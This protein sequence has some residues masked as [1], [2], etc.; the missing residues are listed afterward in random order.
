M[1]IDDNLLEILEDEGVDT[2]PSNGRFTFDVECEVVQ[3]NQLTQNGNRMRINVDRPYDD[4]NL[5][6][7][8]I[9]VI[10]GVVLAV[11]L[12]VFAKATSRWC[13]ADDYDNPSNAK[14]HPRS[15]AGG[16]RPA[17]Q[18]AQVYRDNIDET[19]KSA[20]TR[21]SSTSSSNN[22]VPI[23]S[24]MPTQKNGEW[25]PDSRKSAH[26]YSTPPTKNSNLNTPGSSK[27]K[28]GTIPKTVPIASP[29]SS[30]SS[31]SSSST[32]PPPRPPKD[33]LQY[34]NL[35][36]RAFMQDPKNRVLPGGSLPAS[37]TYATVTTREV[38]QTSSRTF[39]NSP[40]RQ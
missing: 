30:S 14:S 6:G 39:G 7:S 12:L 33:G 31:S 25:L 24:T 3:G 29:S 37:Q 16:A 28:T 1:G 11:A 10:V 22:P 15:Q 21:K 4:G 13:F 40:P 36:H 38:T 34:A 2:N 23:K 20:A 8:M 5:K 9:G 35:D 19:K 26:G 17:N 27:S 32:N 18:Q